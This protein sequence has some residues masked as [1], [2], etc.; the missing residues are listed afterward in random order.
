MNTK[1]PQR[2]LKCVFHSLPCSICWQAW[3]RQRRLRRSQSRPK[4]KGSP[5]NEVHNET[6]ENIRFHML[7]G[8]SIDNIS[9]LFTSQAPI[10]IPTNCSAL[11]ASRLC[12]GTSGTY[13]TLISS[14]TDATW[15]VGSVPWFQHLV[16]P[17]V[18]V[19][20]VT[21]VLLAVFVYRPASL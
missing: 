11:H 5:P 14:I 17:L 4:L 10:S 13:N 18:E 1:V 9:W 21:V 2:P 8:R 7:S 15:D 12:D 16:Y 3:M 19:N 20:A 6:W